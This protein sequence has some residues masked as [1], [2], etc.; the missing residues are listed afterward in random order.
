MPFDACPLPRLRRPR[1]LARAARAGMAIYRRERDLTGV[2]KDRAGRNLVD[3]LT[4][5]EAACEA[6]RRADSPAYSVARHVKLLTALLAEARI[7]A[8]AAA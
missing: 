1:L 5:A 3:A 8:L 4:E 2:L 7:A 6:L